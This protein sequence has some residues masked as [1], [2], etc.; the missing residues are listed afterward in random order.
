MMRK[1]ICLALAA[2]LMLGLTACGST[3]GKGNAPEVASASIV[4][5]NNTKT[6]LKSVG[7]TWL[8]GERAIGSTAM[9][10]ADGSPITETRIVF[11][12]DEDEIPEDVSRSDFGFR[13][14]VLDL[15]DNEW[16]TELYFPL[17]M[18]ETYRFF[19]EE[20]DGLYRLCG[21]RDDAKWDMIQSSNK[22]QEGSEGEPDESM[23]SYDLVGPWHLDETLC[24]GEDLSELF[25]GFAE[26]G[27][28]ME[29]RSDGRISWYIGA[30]SWTGT[31]RLDASGMIAQMKSDLEDTEKEWK[32]TLL[33]PEEATILVMQYE[34]HDLVWS[35]G[36]QEDPPAGE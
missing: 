14:N 18:N 33:K 21:E 11:S 19:L 20:E 3:S 10:P 31:Y 27:S 22:N 35:Y 34:D 15:E 8:Y 28:S 2:L 13:L 9:R 25:P 17:E 7:A 5:Q 12:I 1:I 16:W 26:W 29:I 36:E 24:T 30:E 32:L 6:D 4:V 23:N